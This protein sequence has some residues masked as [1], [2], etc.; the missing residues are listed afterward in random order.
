MV[1]FICYSLQTQW[2]SSNLSRP[3]RS[4]QVHCSPVCNSYTLDEILDKLRG[5]LFIAVFDMTKGFFH[6]PLDKKSKLLTAMLTS[7]GTYIYN[8]LAMGL[9]D[10][11][12]L[13]E[14]CIHQLL[15]DLEGILNIV[16]D[17]IVFGRTEQSLIQM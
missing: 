4:E 5:S 12:D 15:Q 13:F 7:Y 8:V 17:I 10:A 2:I 14:I 11:T 9:A 6:V 16:D 3:N 1:E